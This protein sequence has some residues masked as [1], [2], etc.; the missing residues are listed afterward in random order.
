VLSGLVVQV[1]EG[2]ELGPGPEELLVVRVHEADRE[3]PGL[4]AG[5]ALAKPAHRLVGD[6]LVVVVALLLVADGALEVRAGR[7]REGHS[8]EAVGLEV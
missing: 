1:V 6:V 2:L 3:A 8:V 7:V 5:A 4:V